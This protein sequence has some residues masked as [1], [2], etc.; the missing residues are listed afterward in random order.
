MWDSFRWQSGAEVQHLKTFA[1]VKGEAYRQLEPMADLVMP[2]K[3][4]PDFAYHGWSYC[5]RTPDRSWF[6]LYFEDQ[7]PSEAKLRGVDVG[8]KYRP[9]FFDPRSG[10]W[11]EPGDVLTV[12]RSSVLVLPQRPDTQDWGLMLERV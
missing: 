9:R 3:A 4:G 6:M 12:P 8:A 2:N 10:Q 1:M 5:A 11:G 7:A